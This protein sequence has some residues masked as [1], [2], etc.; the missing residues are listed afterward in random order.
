MWSKNTFRMAFTLWN[1]SSCGPR[2]PWVSCT[3]RA[4]FP[5]PEESV[6]VRSG[7]AFFPVPEDTVPVHSGRALFPAPEDTV[8]VRS[9]RAL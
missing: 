8:H 9:G 6:P 3:G 5:A 2:S 4:L 7:R 1:V